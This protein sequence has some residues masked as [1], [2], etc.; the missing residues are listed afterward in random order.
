[1][2]ANYLS[3]G[4]DTC[5]HKAQHLYGGGSGALE[6]ALCEAPKAAGRLQGMA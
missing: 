3:L 6:R 2:A 1:M 4:L 5:G